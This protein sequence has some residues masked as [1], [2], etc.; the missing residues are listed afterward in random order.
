[1]NEFLSAVL[2]LLLW[3]IGDTDGAAAFSILPLV[4]L[5]A[6]GVTYTFSDDVDEGVESI[7]RFF[8][9]GGPSVVRDAD[10]KVYENTGAKLV[11]IDEPQ[12]RELQG[13]AIPP[14]VLY[15]GAAVAGILAF[16]WAVKKI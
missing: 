11:E 9:G 13:P 6:A 4:V 7:K 5:S 14:I 8:G 1:M 10:G 12:A 15:G 3:L 2:Q 16:V